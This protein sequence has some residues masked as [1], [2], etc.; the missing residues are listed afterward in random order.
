MKKTIQQLA[1]E[2]LKENFP[3]QHK[4]AEDGIISGIVRDFA[5]FADKFLDSQ[6]PQEKPVCK[7]LISSL[8]FDGFWWM[9]K[10]CNLPHIPKPQPPVEK[11]EELSDMK[12][13]LVTIG[14]DVLQPILDKIN[15]LIRAFNKSHE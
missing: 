12:F 2:W 14:D 3:F 15:E 9:C 4:R 7:C 6:A 11:I 1:E 5:Q 10:K 8:E 13:S